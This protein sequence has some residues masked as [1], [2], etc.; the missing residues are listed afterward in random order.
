MSNDHP[1][2]ATG[3]GFR[4]SVTPESLRKL[5]PDQLVGERK[6]IEHFYNKFKLKA[7]EAARRGE[8]SYALEISDAECGVSSDF[9]VQMVLKELTDLFKKEGF[10]II[11]KELN[12]ALNTALLEAAWKEST[13]LSAREA[14]KEQ[15]Q[16]ATVPPTGGYQFNQAMMEQL[17]ANYQMFAQSTGAAQQQ[18]HYPQYAPWGGGWT[19]YVDQRYPVDGFSGYT[20]VSPGSDMSPQ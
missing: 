17:A 15:R 16:L 9:D 18:H 20:N 14:E 10:K 1:L 6:A 11:K 7:E 5:M 2:G 19:G 4:T 3:P 8:S 12:M 13:K